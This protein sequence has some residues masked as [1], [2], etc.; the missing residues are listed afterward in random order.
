MANGPGRRRLPVVFCMVH[1]VTSQSASGSGNSIRRTV[2]GQH[3]SPAGARAI[4]MPG[5]QEPG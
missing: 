1:T 5:V 4:G 3:G 2:S